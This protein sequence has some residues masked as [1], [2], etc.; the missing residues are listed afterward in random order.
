LDSLYDALQKHANATVLRLS[1]SQQANLKKLFKS[2]NTDEFTHIVLFI[3]TKKE[4]RQLG[5]IRTI[6]KLVIIE[7]D[8]SQNYLA[9]KY[10]GK[11]S[12]YYRTVPWVRIFC[13]GFNVTQ[14]LQHEG[15]D[16]FFLSKGYDHNMLGNISIERDIELGFL[17]ST[18]SKV[19]SDRKAFLEQLKG[20][21][22]LI[23]TRTN[24]GQE[25]LQMLNRIRFFISADIG[26]GEHMLKNFEA[27]ACGC[28][29]FC[30]DQGDDENNALGL[31]DMKTAVL[32][33]SLDELQ[34]KLATIR[35]N[36][37]LAKYIAD[38]GQKLSEENF[39]WAC[40][41]K[42]FADNLNSQPLR[43][44]KVS[45]LLGFKRYT[46]SNL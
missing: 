30:W 20:R 38:A 35:A 33:R 19:Y 24:S 4:L 31:V 3:R 18:Q 36:P 22:D 23:I 42:N 13:S 39:T 37:Q 1:S 26:L 17:G 45:S 12:K 9:G 7:H 15:F 34:Q 5:F 21:E 10:N 27:M 46:L 6:P 16:A 8:A 43:K 14:K 44:R 41:A 11:F 32:Y 25:Y 40:V 2:I 29:L 28:L